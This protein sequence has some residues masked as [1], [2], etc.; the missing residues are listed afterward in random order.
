MK[1]AQSLIT[2]K[3]S[4]RKTILFTVI[5]AY[6]Y[7]QVCHGY[8]SCKDLKQGNPNILSGEYTFYNGE[9][10]T[11]KA[12]CEFY[13]TYGY[14]FISREAGVAIKPILID[15]NTTEVLI[16]HQRTTGKQYDTI[17]NQ[18]SA[19]S[20]VPLS[21][22]YNSYVDYTRPHNYETMQPYLYL[23]FLP[24]GVAKAKNVQGYKAN[25]QDYTFKNCD[26]RPHSYIAF[27]FNP[28]HKDPTNYQLTCC[29]SDLMHHWLDTG[30]KAST[31]LNQC[32]FFQIEI[33][34]GGCGG[35]AVNGFNTMEPVCGAALGMRFDF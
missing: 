13:D 18:I 20:S 32:Y 11:Y 15:Y 16:K 8:H 33:H 4:I 29:Y 25:G 9:G 24:R 26:R 5:V 19:K 23:G 31:Y 14:M 2:I 27:F 10:Q 21:I 28:D 22:Q 30:K 12:F 3:M 7:I 17:M 34:M 6:F 35:Y 1:K